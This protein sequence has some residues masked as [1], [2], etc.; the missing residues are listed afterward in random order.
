MTNQ[1]FYDL[2]RSPVVTEKSTSLS[3]HNKIMF[4]VPVDAN[5]QEIKAAVEQLFG[6]KVK[7]V[8]TIK[9][10]GKTKRFKG[11]TGTRSDYKKAILTLKEGESV[12]VMAGAK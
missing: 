7:S 9:V 12:D 5:K 10:H 1:R 2:I 4:K 6:V 8:N 11:Q 3:E